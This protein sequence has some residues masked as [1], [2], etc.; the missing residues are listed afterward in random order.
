MLYEKDY[1]TMRMLFDIAQDVNKSG[2]SRIAAALVVKNDIIAVGWNQ[3]KSSP[4][5]ARHSK[6]PEA[7]FTH[8][9]NHTI[10]KAIK[11]LSFNPQSNRETDLDNIR[12]AFRRATLYIARAKFQSSNSDILQWGLSRPCKGCFEAIR[13]YE[14]RRVVYSLNAKFG[15]E[16]AEEMKLNWSRINK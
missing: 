3:S 14:I 1:K 12:R 15:E 4:F 6:N 16:Y 2:G 7:I 5:Q 13:K 11:N 8:A 9:E 10:F